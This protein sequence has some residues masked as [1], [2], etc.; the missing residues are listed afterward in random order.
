MLVLVEKVG[1]VFQYTRFVGSLLTD[2]IQSTHALSPELVEMYRISP[3][4]VCP[5]ESA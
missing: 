3:E 5:K 4:E 1:N 2:Q